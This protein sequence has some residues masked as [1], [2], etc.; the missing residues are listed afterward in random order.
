LIFASAPAMAWDECQTPEIHEITSLG[1][2]ESEAFDVN[3][4]Y[5]I[6]GESQVPNGDTHAFLFTFR[7]G[8]VDIGTLES[9]NY[10]SA[11]AITNS[12]KVVGVANITPNGNVNR[13]FVWEKGKGI[14]GLPPLNGAKDS[15]ANDIN[16]S[17]VIVGSSGGVATVWEHGKVRSLGTLGGE[18][19][20][21]NGINKRGWIVGTSTTKDGYWHAFKYRDGRI[22]DLGTLAGHN[23]YGDD[24][25]D[26]GQ[27]IGNSDTTDGSVHACVWQ[28][29]KLS[30]ADFGVG[31]STGNA[32][33]ANGLGT[34]G[35]TFQG[36]H[37][38]AALWDWNGKLVDLGTLPGADFSYG[39]AVND[40]KIIVGYSYGSTG[41]KAVYWQCDHF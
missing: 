17:G 39:H 6:V 8:I 16:E 26:E 9:G 4:S 38:H 40:G 20:Y 41:R 12:G 21:A 3:E 32:I 28:H 15:V 22:Y 7:D 25:N 24:V 23:S 29:N 2:T 11:N 13:A 30:D 33:S 5:M 18:I 36:G 1:G 27:V 34:G 10:S 35:A 19:S 14:R 31:G 37:L